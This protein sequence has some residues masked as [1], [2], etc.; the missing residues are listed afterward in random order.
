MDGLEEEEEVDPEEFEIEG[1]EI[2]TEDGDDEEQIV[3]A[4]SSSF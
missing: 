1:S 3:C 2:V 4:M